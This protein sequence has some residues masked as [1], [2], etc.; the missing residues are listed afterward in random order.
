[1]NP[2]ESSLSPTLSAPSPV[3][4]GTRPIDT[5]SRSKVA[6]CAVPLASV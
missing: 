3:V 6:V 1:M 4:S 2:R 5:I